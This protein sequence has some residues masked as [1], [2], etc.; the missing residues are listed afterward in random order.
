MRDFMVLCYGG[1]LSRQERRVLSQKW[2]AWILDLGRR[3]NLVWAGF[4]RPEG[5]KIESRGVATPDHPADAETVK[6]YFVVR[7]HTLE[8]AVELS[9]RCPHLEVD[10]SLE[11][12]EVSNFS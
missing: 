8:E 11:V 1:D 4:L 2:R 3:G 9:M 10:G 5:K 6:G 7:A 12:R